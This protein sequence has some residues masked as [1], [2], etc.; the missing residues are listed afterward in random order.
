MYAFMGWNRAFA[1]QAAVPAYPC[2]ID[3]RHLLGELLGIVNV[4]TAV[5]IDEQGAIVRPP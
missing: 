2:L 1:E 4:P 3:E 5:W